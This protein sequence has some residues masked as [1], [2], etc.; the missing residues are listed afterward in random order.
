MTLPALLAG[1]IL[2]R[3]RPEEITIW[4]ATSKS[5]PK[6][7]VRIL[8]WSP[9]GV[10]PIAIRVR[11]LEIPAAPNLRVHILRVV[12]ATGSFPTERVLLYD[13]GVGA[14]GGDVLPFDG[15]AIDDLGY[16]GLRLPSLILQR[17]ASRNLNVLYGS[18]R[19]SHGP[20]QD[21]TH[22]ADRLL[23]WHARDAGR[24]PHAL[25]LGGDQIYADDVPAMLIR[26]IQELARAIMAFEEP[27]PGHSKPGAIAVNDRQ[28][29]VR[30]EGSL[31]SEHAANHLMTFGEF[32]A[33]YLIAWNR[34]VWPVLP[35]VDDML[36]E[37][38]VL[39]R[40]MPP[41]AAE[42][43]LQALRSRKLLESKLDLELEL[44]RLQAYW[45]G[46]GSLRRVLANVPTY[47][48]FDDHEITDD[49][50]LNPE[51][52]KAALQ[53]ALG[54][55]VIANGIAAFWLFQG[56]ANDFEYHYRSYIE[57]SLVDH[58][59][60]LK[61]SGNVSA[62]AAAAF[63][64]TFTRRMHNW[65]F[66]TPTSPPILFLDTRTR[67]DKSRDQ[68]LH[69]TYEFFGVPL[70]KTVPDDAPLLFD[71]DAIRLEQLLKHKVLGR[72]ARLILLVPAPVFGV[73]H[74]EEGQTAAARL[75]MKGSSVDLESFQADPN[76]FLDL[77][78][79]LLRLA[80]PGDSGWRLKLAVILSGDVHYGFSVGASLM[81]LKTLAPPLAVAQFT[82]SA[83]KNHP[84]LAL[85][86]AVRAISAALAAHVDRVQ[87]WWREG[88]DNAAHSSI[89]VPAPVRQSGNSYSLHHFTTAPFFDLSVQKAGSAGLHIAE[90]FRFERKSG[91]SVL[92]M[93]NNMGYLQLVGFR[94]R[95]R[96]ISWTGS[97][98]ES[99]NT[100]W[101]PSKSNWPAI[102]RV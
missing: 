72:D 61:A 91:A 14:V 93:A 20:D 33:A 87:F 7:A 10:K 51:R 66:I 56:V 86:G 48:S 2:R 73:T 65:D 69:T 96:L 43:I 90:A 80:T 102:L 5:I 22:A 63:D 95:N 30:D 101:N 49:W 13:V 36:K 98:E 41:N 21:A 28:R 99:L 92:E 27:L 60:G 46:C 18:C 24:R 89:T 62:P 31:S 37:L 16:A 83:V 94:V 97:Y 54:K 29:I 3:C 39:P 15:K 70:R 100:D 25:L 58:V 71:H 4:L 52:R 64:D 42:L 26:P 84:E 44:R 6:L 67:R 34:D 85:A 59:F 8:E 9:S 88:S 35:T 11:P 50:Y 23:E 45:E 76:S 57:K 53:S 55:R 19:K 38:G 40:T 82:S 74:I 1:P 77:A 47:M 75:G 81:D 12:P 17:P 79:L 32:S 68:R 78:A